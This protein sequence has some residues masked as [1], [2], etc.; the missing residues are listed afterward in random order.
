MNSEKRVLD[1]EQWPIIEIATKHS[2]KHFEPSLSEFSPEM[3]D[4]D[5][6]LLSSGVFN[7]TS[8]RGI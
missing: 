8:A 1:T 3:D 4:D 7:P 6:R 2:L 5:D